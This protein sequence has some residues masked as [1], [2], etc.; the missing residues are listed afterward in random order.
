MKKAANNVR[1]Y[2]GKAIIYILL[3]WSLGALALTGH[4]S[5]GLLCLF[6]GLVAYTL[7]PN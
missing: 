7:Y 2:Y 5:L 4:V 6:E 1:K 3:Y